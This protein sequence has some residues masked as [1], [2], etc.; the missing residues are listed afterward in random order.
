MPNLTPE[1]LA[2]IEARCKA[3]TDDPRM[4]YGK[5][6]RLFV[7]IASTDTKDLIAEIKRL[8]ERE[9]EWAKLLKSANNDVEQLNEYINKLRGT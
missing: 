9:E 7:E 6:Q 3:A 2:E 4:L 1:R 8:R 5:R